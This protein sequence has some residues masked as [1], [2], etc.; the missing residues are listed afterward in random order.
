MNCVGSVI[1][2]Y[3]LETEI[4]KE[5]LDPWISHSLRVIYCF[6]YTTKMVQKKKVG[7]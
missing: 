7:L 3:Q 4:Q 5:C 2:K 1:P 6:Y